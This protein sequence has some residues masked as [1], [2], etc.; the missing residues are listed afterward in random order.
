MLVKPMPAKPMP[1]TA[2]LALLATAAAMINA[3]RSLRQWLMLWAV[4]CCAGAASAPDQGQPADEPI[5][6]QEPLEQLTLD[7]ANG[8]AVLRIFPLDRP[9][10][11]DAEGNGSSDTLRIRLLSRPDEQYDVPRKHVVK[12]ERFEQLILAEAEKLTSQGKFGEAYDHYVFLWRRYPELA[13]L[14]DSYRQF[15]VSNAFA[16]YRAGQWEDALVQLSEVRRL[17][18]NRPGLAGGWPRSATSW[19]KYTC[20]EATTR[21]PVRCC[22]ASRA[23]SR[24]NDWSSC[25]K[26]GPPSSNRWPR[27]S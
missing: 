25:G 12:H 2:L 19:W 27:I 16:S 26:N 21:P 15:L 8:N 4:V 18:P 5:Y 3:S 17:E 10:E 14:P 1:V 6:Q 11:K 24:T 13:G 7:E 9:D 23:K 22:T 20:S